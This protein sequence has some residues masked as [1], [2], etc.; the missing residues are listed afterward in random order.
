MS[1]QMKFKVLIDGIGIKEVLAKEIDG[2]YMA[3]TKEFKC[4][5]EDVLAVMPC[6][7]MGQ[8]RENVSNTIGD[9]K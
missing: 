1:K 2:A 3:A 6:V 4:R 7:T 9:C 8:Y 5:I